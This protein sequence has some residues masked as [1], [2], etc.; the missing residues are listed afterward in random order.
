MEENNVVYPSQELPDNIKKF[1]KT[2]KH[3]NL[4]NIYYIKSVDKDG[5]VTDEAYAENLMT[6]YGLRYCTTNL[7]A[8]N[9]KPY[10]STSQTPPTLSD[11]TMSDLFTTSEP[12][13]SDTTQVLY[14]VVYDKD[15][16]IA[17]E[18][19][20]VMEVYWDYNYSGTASDVDLYSIGIFTNAYTSYP[21]TLRFHSLMY[22]SSGNLKHI[23]KR[24]NER[25]YVKIYITGMID[26]D[27]LEDINKRH[28]VN[29]L[30]NP[31]WFTAPSGGCVICPVTATRNSLNQ[32]YYNYRSLLSNVFTPPD[33][34]P[35][36]HNLKNTLIA[37]DDSRLYESQWHTVIGTILCD[38]SYGYSYGHTFVGY[39]FDM[40]LETPEELTT[41]YAGTDSYTSDN[42]E[43]M[44]GGY[45]SQSND[46]MSLDTYYN[47]SN[48]NVLPVSDFTITALK[49]WDFSTHTWDTNDISYIAGDIVNKTFDVGKMYLG[50]RDS[51][52]RLGYPGVS[53]YWRDDGRL[54]T[55][56]GGCAVF[57]NPHPEYEMEYFT[58]DLA[59]YYP[60]PR[61]A[62]TDNYLDISSF[63]EVT[64]GQPLPKH[65]RN[66]KYIVQLGVNHEYTG[67]SS[68]DYHYAEEV[69]KPT[70]TPYLKNRLNLDKDI[71]DISSVWTGKSHSTYRD[72]ISSSDTNEW[73][74]MSAFVVYKPESDT[75]R[76]VLDLPID[77]SPSGATYIAQT[78]AWGLHFATDTKI[79]R[80]MGF[81]NSSYW[82]GIR[83][84]DLSNID[85]DVSLPCQDLKVYNSS[86][87]GNG[88]TC[89]HFS[90]HG[91]LSLYNYSGGGS[92]ILNTAK[93][94]DINASPAS[95]ILSQYTDICMMGVDSDYFVYHDTSVISRTEFV[96]YD[97][98]TQTEVERFYFPTDVTYTLTGIF[99]WKDH[100]YIQYTD[101]NSVS[102]IYYH[103]TYAGA[104]QVSSLNMTHNILTYWKK[105]PITG[106]TSDD[107]IRVSSV[108]DVCVISDYDNA[109][110]MRV[111]TDA[112]DINNVS[113]F[114]HNMTSSTLNYGYNRNIRNPMVKYT[115]DQKTLMLAGQYD[116]YENQGYHIGG[117]AYDLGKIID[118][119]YKQT[120]LYAGFND[121]TNDGYNNCILYKDYVVQTCVSGGSSYGKKTILKLH[122]YERFLKYRMVG[123][124]RTITGWNNPFKIIYK[125]RWTL[126]LSNDMNRILHIVDTNNTKM[127]VVHRETN[128]VTQ[129]DT[130]AE[131]LAFLQQEAIDHPLSL[132]NVYMG[133]N[134]TADSYVASYASTTNL[135]EFRTCPNATVVTNN[136]FSGSKLR[137]FVVHP[138]TQTLEINSGA[139]ANTSDLIEFNISETTELDHFSDSF[140]N[141]GLSEF[142]INSTVASGASVITAN[143]SFANSAKLLK[144]YIKTPETADPNDRLQIPANSFINCTNLIDVQ[145]PSGLQSIGASA[146][147]CTGIPNINLTDCQYIYQS[148]FAVNTTTGPFSTNS[149]TIGGSSMKSIGQNAF[150]GNKN[151]K[152]I[153]LP[154]VESSIDQTAFNNI[155]EYYIKINNNESD[156]S[157]APWGSPSSA[158]ILYMKQD[159]LV[160]YGTGAVN[161]GLYENDQDIVTITF[162]ATPSSIDAT[163]FAGCDNVT[164]I[165]VPWS[166]G[167]ITGAPWGAAH[168]TVH[169]DQT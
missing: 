73:I 143:G 146:F 39:K 122:P 64:V 132:Y 31:S 44:F 75:Y 72:G 35:V 27:I 131:V 16:H 154:E 100:I 54:Y 24:Q 13:Y 151:L 63:Q 130:Q 91:Y 90:K 15:T 158:G 10:V 89:A 11:T 12:A 25:L 85:T 133:D 46:Q 121:L 150:S 22:D 120:R 164:D 127:N 140:T 160:I 82:D 102:N 98:S 163:A 153:I 145:F 129:F 37:N 138:D 165:Y 60:S 87:Y 168:A 166:S 81:T 139:F 47:S 71:I 33:R 66:M 42:F 50:Y 17:S 125:T 84:Y 149:L 8:G 1:M 6:D 126:T 30:M 26:V 48:M 161:K 57:M 155:P 45:C 88:S 9:F 110:I 105:Y 148:A 38:G 128:E 5:N 20:F 49:K 124:T 52:L 118:D 147:Y 169:Y 159:N 19:L 162:N 167:D 95:V 86:V 80:M 94:I 7:N 59:Y 69:A 83:I 56:P 65:V 2:I 108:E 136:A 21:N 101:S 68:L 4:H 103:Q 97:C 113:T 157:Y 142:I 53:Y 144:V 135:I 79:A 43:A 156:L 74:G 55:I 117:V 61:Y 18:S 41:N 92:G 3:G 32:S 67:T 76:K 58:N 115:T 106:T 99:V 114:G 104:S 70:S 116:H 78:A 34:G 123:T 134:F 137:R 29:M 109:Y 36:D 51:V 23:T 112:P 111:I 28:G 119:G 40:K 152:H 77:D 14:N 141:T 96:I 93:V 107:Y 62:M